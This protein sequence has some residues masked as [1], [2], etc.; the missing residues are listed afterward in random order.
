MASM[1]RSST[2]EVRL[3]VWI[4]ALTLAQALFFGFIGRDLLIDHFVDEVGRKARALAEVLASR[5][6]VRGLLADPPT[7]NVTAVRAE[8]ARLQ[9]EAGAD[10]IVV[11][12]EHLIRR[13]HP[14]AARLGKRMTGGDSARALMGESFVARA[15]G[16]L[17]EAI[18]GK[19]PVRA[20]L[21]GEIIGLV[22]VG[23]LIDS[24]DRDVAGREARI[25]QWLTVSVLG[26]L[27]VAVWVGRQVRRATFG[28]QPEEIGR[29]YAEQ[30][31]I[32]ETVQTGI[33]ALD[34]AGGVRRINRRAREILGLPTHRDAPVPSLEELFPGHAE[35]L[36]QP[37]EA[38]ISGWELFAAG[39]RLVMSRRPL[40]AREAP[41]GCLLSMRPADELEYLSQELARVRALA[42]SMRL[43]THEYANKLN[44]LG[45]LLQV[46][47]H[48]E[49]VEMI[50]RET[51]GLQR[52]I[53]EV[54]DN[55]EDPVAASLL[56]GKYHQALEAG[57]QLE[58]NLGGRL[59]G[60]R[61]PAWLERFVTIVGNLADNAID[62]ALEQKDTEPPRVSVSVEQLGDNW[63]VDVEDSGAGLAKSLDQLC[64]PGVSSKPGANRG[65]GLYLVKTALEQGGGSVEVGESE[66]GGARVTVYLPM[67]GQELRS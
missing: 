7:V 37:P 61:D 21:D 63:V 20:G 44:T 50:G 23:Y 48:D 52:R 28:L 6:D 9:A 40:D 26:G 12:D 24:I 66:L 3:G 30:E 45:T 32:L 17:G 16:T 38:P 59:L 47:A 4:T 31:A 43:Q 41:A 67:V 29:L 5:P 39:K 22:S 25:L 2:L 42:E 46:G 27:L 58:L 15:V 33:I 35:L 60:Q 10:Y 64:V 49:A 18:R 55:V 13:A 36:A 51:R 8:L 56:L 54:L 19:A 62:A 34:H 11:G 1:F 53:H 14:V 65:V 57:V